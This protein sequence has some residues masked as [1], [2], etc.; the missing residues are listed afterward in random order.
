MGNA[1]TISCCKRLDLLKVY[2]YFI[3]VFLSYK[4]TLSDQKKKR[5]LK[6]TI[7]EYIVQICV[8]LQ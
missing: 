6:S 8:Q 2:N 4:L 5:F 3:D 7:H 1:D